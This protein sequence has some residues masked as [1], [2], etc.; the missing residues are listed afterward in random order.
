MSLRFTKQAEEGVEESVVVEE[1]EDDEKG[2]RKTR[3]QKQSFLQPS[4]HTGAAE[5]GCNKIWRKLRS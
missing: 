4:E 2:T 3:R 1:E 5:H